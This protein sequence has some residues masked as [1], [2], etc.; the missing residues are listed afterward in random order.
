MHT[1]ASR[2]RWTFAL[3]V[4]DDDIR[5]SVEDR[6]VGLPEPAA[7]IEDGSGGLGVSV[8]QAL[9]CELRLLPRRGA[10]RRC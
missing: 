4:V 8:M 9:A 2:D 7:A 10:G 6:G 1:R 5:V 3:F